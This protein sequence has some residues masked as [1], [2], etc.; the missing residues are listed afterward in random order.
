MTEHFDAYHRWLGIAPKHQPPTYYRLLGIE[1]FESDPEVIADAAERQI[2]HVRRYALGQHAAL[3]QRILN[4]LSQ[5]KAVLLDPGRKVSYDAQLR[6]LR[7]LQPAPVA[8]PTLQV[9]VPASPSQW[10]ATTHPHA[11]FAQPTPYIPQPQYAYVPPQPAVT[12]HVA[13]AMPAATSAPICESNAPPRTRLATT[14]RR[15]RN[16]WAISLSLHVV[17]AFC[18]LSVGYALI[19][20][21]DSRYDFLGLMNDEP[22][23]QKPEPAGPPVQ[24]KP[25]VRPATIPPERP[26]TP[27]SASLVGRRT[28]ELRDDNALRLKL[29]WCI[30]GRFLLGSPPDEPGRRL[31]EHRVQVTHLHGFWLGQTEVTQ[32]QWRAVM[33]SE[34]WHGKSNVRLGPDYPA[35]YVSW[36]DAMEFCKLLTE[37]ERQAGRLPVGWEYTLPTETQWEYACRAGT[38]TPYSFGRSITQLSQ[39]AWY[40]SNALTRGE[41]YPHRV[42]QKLANPWGLYDMHGNVREWCADWYSPVM[43][44]GVNPQGPLSG[45]ER[46]RRG[47]CWSDSAETCRSAFRD[48]V[49]P[50]YRNHSLGFR[51]ALVRSI[52]GNNP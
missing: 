10:P 45:T 22:A 39:Y 26:A 9:P 49:A 3:S 34:P 38:M 30:P 31:S 40:R 41:S 20:Y 4:E 15:K 14:A 7:G 12:P 11:T 44:G 28:G 37:I 13:P 6:A 27:P 19:C 25:E 29:V 35:T 24:T 18:G 52:R 51:V 43:I 8:A 32:A 16:V 1:E 50:S 36:D 5:A 46:V 23:P 42:A 2:V 17:A 33:Q 21:Y 47:G 48:G